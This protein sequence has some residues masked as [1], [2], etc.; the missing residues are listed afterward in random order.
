MSIRGR[1]IVEHRNKDGRLLNYVNKHNT[2]T[3]LG[4]AASLFFGVS[5]LGIPN[6][7]QPGLVYPDFNSAGSTNQ[8][9]QGQT[10]NEDTVVECD[11]LET[12]AA[13]IA[14][15]SRP[16]LFV[17][18]D[19]DVLGF[20]K[21]KTATGSLAAKEGIRVPPQNSSKQ[22][23]TATAEGN[24][25]SFSFRWTDIEGDLRTVTM[26]IPSLLLVHT[27]PSMF[28]QSYTFIPEQHNGVP[29][30]KIVAGGASYNKLLDLSTDAITD[31]TPTG[32]YSSVTRWCGLKFG[33]YL[34]ECL[35]DQVRVTNTVNGTTYTEN[36]SGLRGAWT[37]NGT[38]YLLT[39]T[40]R[41]FTCYSATVSD[42][43]I[44]ATVVTLADHVASTW[45][46]QY[47][48]VAGLSDDSVVILSYVDGMANDVP[49]KIV[50]KLT[51]TTPIWSATFN[52]D[53]STMC[54]YLDNII[55][56]TD[57]SISPAG[58]F[59]IL[60]SYLDLESS[61]PINA[62]DTVTVTYTYELEEVV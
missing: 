48:Y 18:E 19:N 59:G 61:W 45:Q 54:V 55:N 31:F 20:A 52:A 2:I 15:S 41:T 27:L 23:I 33:D 51:D 5:A 28:S 42:S 56:L 58:Q 30:G 57:S 21:E 60:F 38:L 10:K 53:F 7:V 37:E 16:E 6:A 43:A 12:S 62:T 9:N 47:L 14:A 11:L 40:S 46:N 3:E 44:T 22:I 34:I 4:K 25:A 35:T 13:T 24:T 8:D 29:T 32:S 49:A 39:Y 36:W 26:K 1:V 17:P 50:Q